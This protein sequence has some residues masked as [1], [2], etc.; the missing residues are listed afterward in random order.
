MNK[1]IIKVLVIIV[2]LPV[3]LL[4][5][6]IIGFHKYYFGANKPNLKDGSTLFWTKLRKTLSLNQ[7]TRFYSYL[8]IDRILYL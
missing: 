5:F 7:K 8:P 3:F 1:K 2:I 6:N 4:S